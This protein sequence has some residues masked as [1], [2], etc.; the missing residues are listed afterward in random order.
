MATQIARELHQ[1]GVSV[2]LD[3]FCGAGGNA[4][5][6]ARE[7]DLVYAWDVDPVKI[8]VRQQMQSYTNAVR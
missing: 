4:I 8:E 5:A 3:P 6:F 7:M 2:I 1:C